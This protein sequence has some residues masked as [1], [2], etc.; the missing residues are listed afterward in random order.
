MLSLSSALSRL[1]TLWSKSSEVVNAHRRF[2]GFFL[3][4]GF[5]MIQSREYLIPWIIRN[6]FMNMEFATVIGVLCVVLLGLV[7]WAPMRYSP[8]TLRRE[9]DTLPEGLAEGLIAAAVVSCVYAAGC[10]IGV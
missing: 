10:R 1:S 7:L 5:L 9:I 2:V 8:E 4:F 3:A 6:G